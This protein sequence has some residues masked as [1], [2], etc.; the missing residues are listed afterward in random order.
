[1]RRT[2]PPNPP[3]A[4]RRRRSSAKD[5]AVIGVV[6]TYN[7]GVAAETAPVLEKAGIVQISPGNTDPTLTLGEHIADDPERQFDNYFRLLANDAKQG[8]VLADY[9]AGDLGAT[10]VAV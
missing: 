8:V 9:A 10:T 4:R 1:M 3:S 6:G 7:S 2:T 5:P